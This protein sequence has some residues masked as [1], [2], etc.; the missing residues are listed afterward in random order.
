[1]VAT[2]GPLRSVAGFELDAVE[3]RV[4]ALECTTTDHDKRI[5]S[6]ELDGE[7]TRTTIKIAAAIVAIVFATGAGG[8]G[9]LVSRI[10]TP[11]H[12]AAGR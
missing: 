3:V 4:H 6:I 2:S 5:R 8:V 9:W 10:A 7:R 1:M 12:A 11:T